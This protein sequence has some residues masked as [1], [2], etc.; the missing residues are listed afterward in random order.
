MLKAHAD[1]LVL[2]A[3]FRSTPLTGYR[4]FS[5]KSVSETV[6]AL[7]PSLFSRI[8]TIMVS[9]TNADAAAEHQAQ[10]P[11]FK[12]RKLVG[13]KNFKRCNPQSDK[14]DIRRFHHVELWCG[15]A[16]NTARR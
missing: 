5:G 2:H 15:D 3:V 12:R 9:N 13:Y 10:A 11:Q 7:P 8:G 6:A 16:T 4:S 1:L 14:F